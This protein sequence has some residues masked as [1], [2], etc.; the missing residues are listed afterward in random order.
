MAAGLNSL[1]QQPLFQRTAGDRGELADQPIG[2]LAGDRQAAGALEALDRRLGVRIDDAGR[3]DLAVAEVGQRP[4][5]RITRRSGARSAAIGS[6]RVGAG[7]CWLRLADEAQ[8]IAAARRRAR[9]RASVLPRARNRGW[10]RRSSD[11]SGRHGR[12][13]RSRGARARAGCRR[14]LGSA[15][16]TGAAAPG[17]S[18][19]RARRQRWHAGASQRP[20]RRQRLVGKI[21]AGCGPD[22]RNRTLTRI[23]SVVADRE[24][25]AA[26]CGRPPP[27]QIPDRGA[28]DTAATGVATVLKSSRAVRTMRSRTAFH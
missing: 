4:L 6:L 22:C 26:V 20:A 18:L 15:A 21:G 16:A 19:G 14:R 23:A 7:G 5:Y 3:L 12:R 13:R 8:W 1:P 27:H 2:D 9:S 24:Q 11:H 28:D 10:R 17:A 25:I